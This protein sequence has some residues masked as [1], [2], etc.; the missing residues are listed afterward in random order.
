MWMIQTGLRGQFIQQTGIE[1]AY[2]PTGS[3]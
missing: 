3:W 1:S 2:Y